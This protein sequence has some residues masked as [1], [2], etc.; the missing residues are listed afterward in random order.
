MIKAF[1][2]ILYSPRSDEKVNFDYFVW[3]LQILLDFVDKESLFQAVDT[4]LG[5]KWKIEKF[6]LFRISLPFQ[7]YIQSKQ[8]TH[9]QQLSLQSIQVNMYMMSPTIW[10]IQMQETLP[11]SCLCPRIIYKDWS[12]RIFLNLNRLYSFESTKT[13]LLPK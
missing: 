6:A 7:Q 10:W 5:Y 9:A 13:M 12:R 3:T 4:Q 8:M 2:S 1:L 11:L